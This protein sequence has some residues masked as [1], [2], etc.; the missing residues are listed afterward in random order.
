MKNKL[1]RVFQTCYKLKKH[2]LK[3]Y[4]KSVFTKNILKVYK[5]II[6]FILVKYSLKLLKV[7]PNNMDRVHGPKPKNTTRIICKYGIDK[8]KKKVIFYARHSY[9]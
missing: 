1:G 3:I 5:Y 9:T 8:K 4:F 2:R 6:N 7:Q